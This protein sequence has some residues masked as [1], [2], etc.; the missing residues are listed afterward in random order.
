MLLPDLPWV[1]TCDVLMESNPITALTMMMKILTNQSAICV[2]KS[3][4]TT[5]NTDVHRIYRT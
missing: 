3:P 5:P 1:P 2:E 4:H